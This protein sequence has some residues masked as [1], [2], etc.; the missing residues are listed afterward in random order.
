[1]AAGTYRYNYPPPDDGCPQPSCC[2]PFPV[3]DLWTE[4][5]LASLKNPMGKRVLTP[6]WGH[7]PTTFI[8]I[9]IVLVLPLTFSF[10]SFLEFPDCF[11]F[12]SYVFL[13][14]PLVVF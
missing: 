2:N 8:S 9:L 14:D 13:G 10:L 5:P 12:I 6:S 1:M 7:V 4:S 11:S 3:V